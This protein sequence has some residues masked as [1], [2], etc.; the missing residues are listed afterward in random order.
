[1]KAVTARDNTAKD[2]TVKAG[3]VKDGTVNF[4]TVLST[5]IATPGGVISQYH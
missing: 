5:R 2:S 1:M 4:G 3:T